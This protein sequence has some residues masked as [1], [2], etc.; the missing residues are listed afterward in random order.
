MMQR[1]GE[2]SNKETSGTGLKVDVGEASRSKKVDDSLFKNSETES[3]PRPLRRT[4][5]Q[6]TFSSGLK[7]KQQPFEKLRNKA[8]LLAFDRC[9]INPFG[10]VKSQRT[11]IMDFSVFNHVLTHCSKVSNSEPR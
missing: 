6:T 4:S 1:T 10:L 8:E 9:L 7:Q 11:L 5:S 2:N 3:F